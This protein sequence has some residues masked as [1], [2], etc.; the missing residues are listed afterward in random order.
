MEYPARDY[1]LRHPQDVSLKTYHG[2]SVVS[3]LIRCYFS[4]AFSTGQRYIYTGS[5]EGSIHIYDLVT[6]EKVR[7]VCL[8]YLPPSTN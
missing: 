3:T 1:D 2:H 6:G 8:Y 4:P 5:R 7:G